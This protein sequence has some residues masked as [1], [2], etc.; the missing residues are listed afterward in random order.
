MGCSW[1]GGVCWEGVQES[2]G[3]GGGVG[4]VQNEGG[5]WEDNNRD[6]ENIPLV[7]LH[8]T[9]STE[10]RTHVSCTFRRHETVIVTLVKKKLK[11]CIMVY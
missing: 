7:L 8:P 10:L 5:G 2:G 9:Y 3:G 11:N 1:F 6:D 4:G